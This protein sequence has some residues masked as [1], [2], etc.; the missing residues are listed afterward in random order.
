MKIM[1]LVFHPDLKTSRVNQTWKRQLENSGKLALSRDLYREYPDFCIDVE[2]EQSMLMAHDRIV[3]QFPLYWY[4]V[5]PLLKKWMDDVLTQG[6]AYGVAGDKLDGKDLQLL[7]SVGGRHEFYN[8][9]DIFCTIPDLLRPFQLTANLTRM[10][11]LIPEWMYEADTASQDTIEKNGRRW[12]TI[13]DDPR[14]SNPRKYLYDTMNSDLNVSNEA[15][16]PGYDY[17]T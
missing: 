17:S 16:V 8:G 12:I 5:P 10:N 11:Y 4:S 1:N 9:F 2:K 6:F 7:V 14:R 15:A 3:I 13:I